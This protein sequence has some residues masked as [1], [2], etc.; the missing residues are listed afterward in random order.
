MGGNGISWTICK[1]FAPHSRQITTPVPHHSIFFT[2]Q[3][4]FLMPNQQ[5]QSTEGHMPEYIS[6]LLMPVAKKLHYV[7]HQVNKL[8][9]E[10]SVLPHHEHGTGYRQ[11]WSCCNWWTNFV[12]YWKYF[13]CLWSPG[14]ELTLWC[15]VG[16]PVG[17]Q[18]KYLSYM[19]C[20]DIPLSV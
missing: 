15:A 7:P 11:S 17:A 13:D 2:G 3:M 19:L 12:V 10:L 18:Y 4:L 6:D 8:V 20:D 1:S 9:T 16:L 5:C 14:Y